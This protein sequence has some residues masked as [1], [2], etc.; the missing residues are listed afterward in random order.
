MHSECRDGA[1]YVSGDVTV[2]TVTAPLFRAYCQQ[3]GYLK[4]SSRPTV[5]F[6]GVGQA[7]SVC[8][9]LLAAAKRSLPEAD[10]AFP[11]IPAGVAELA[12]LYEVGDWIPS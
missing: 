6:S 12:K 1:V 11:G 8:I 3:L 5:D 9:S 4:N 7:D 10:W 2:S